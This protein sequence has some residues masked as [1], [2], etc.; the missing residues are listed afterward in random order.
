ML[1]SRN[2][3]KHDRDGFMVNEDTKSDSDCLTMQPLQLQ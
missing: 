2:D 3:G 1:R